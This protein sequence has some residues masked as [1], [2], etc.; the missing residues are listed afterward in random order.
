VDAA[1]AQRDGAVEA[2]G[3]E[4]GHAKELLTAQ[5]AERDAWGMELAR[6][7]R[8][9]DELEQVATA[10]SERVVAR[11]RELSAI[12]AE[13]SGTR[14]SGEANVA[15]L[16]AAV[17]ELE[18]V[19]GQAR[20]QATRIRLHALRDA[21]EI[22][23][24]VGELS[25]RPA[26]MRDRLLEALAEA[27]ERLGVEAEMG[28]AA[29]GASANGHAPSVTEEGVFEGSVE[30]EIGPLRDFSQLVGFEDAAKEI[31]ATTDITVKRFSEGRATLAMSLDA[32]VELLREL[33]ERCDLEFA[34]RDARS[35][36]L[37][38]DVGDTPVE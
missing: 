6:R 15:A 33:E 10:L 23:D 14:A 11:E 9:L 24:R 29:N 38:L 18:A 19:R 21:A 4:L 12:R 17:R 8:R 27:I 35:D 20:G 13:L 36:R 26:E 1:L 22:A 37:V 2:I 7:D 16:A 28:V 31:A 34:V 5:R 32:P 25:R 3:E 30:V